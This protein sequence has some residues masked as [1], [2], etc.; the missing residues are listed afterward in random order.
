MK[1]KVLSSDLLKQLSSLSGVLSSA[2]ALPILDCFLFE[3]NKKSLK[4][5]ASD[6][7]TVISASMEIESSDTGNIAVPAK[8]LLETL[9]AFP[10]QPLTFNIDEKKNQIELSS[11]YGKYKLVGYPAEDFPKN[12]E[13]EKPSS[14]EIDGS[15]FA[16][17]INKTL[18]AVGSDD[19]R[20]V[21]CGVFFKIDASGLTFVAT[22]A[23]KLSKYSIKDIK[24]KAEASYIVPKKPLSL[25]K[26]ISSG[27]KI[28]IQYN[29]T[30]ASFDFDNVQITTRLIDGKYP[31]YDAVIPKKNE[32][33]MTID[34]AEF[35]NSIRRVSIYS[36]R[37]T[38]MAKL[39]IK[40]NKLNIIA[41]DMDF[42]N[43]ANEDVKCEYR[44][45]DIEIG[46][47][48]KYLSEILNSL[49]GDEVNLQMSDASHA[50]VFVPEKS[51]EDVLMLLMPVL[52]NN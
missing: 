50:G 7:E 47:N 44:G 17:A 26:S 41:Q 34:R 46:F 21:M 36:N 25:I 2:N 22:D 5:T 6:L 14:F 43:E 35:L 12:P 30:N 19:L 42:S 37:N 8:M 11:D 3:I 18:F 45:S 28:K 24:S 32:N 52:L 23:H 15:L 38:H 33:V 4:I 51:K 27:G 31:N 16:N 1:F 13:I 9:K 10:S 48:S 40:K 39:S 20:P 49:D 29:G